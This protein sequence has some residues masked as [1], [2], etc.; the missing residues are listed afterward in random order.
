MSQEEVRPLCIS[1]GQGVS[2]RYHY[3]PPSSGKRITSALQ[4]HGLCSNSK[5]LQIR[6]EILSYETA[7]G[8]L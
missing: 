7:G 5:Q 6:E 2:G 1:E 3:G 4:T 8:V